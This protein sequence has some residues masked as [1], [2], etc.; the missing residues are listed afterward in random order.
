MSLTR[1]SHE[2]DGRAAGKGRAKWTNEVGR[3]FIRPDSQV[4]RLGPRP[5]FAEVSAMVVVVADDD[6]VG[7]V[8][9]DVVVVVI[10]FESEA[11]LLNMRPSTFFLKLS[12]AWLAPAVS[13]LSSFIMLV[14]AAVCGTLKV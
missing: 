13:L 7:V 1:S 11:I 8:V 9:V 3:P 12:S 14:G 10:F 6:V 5:A 4:T 2:A